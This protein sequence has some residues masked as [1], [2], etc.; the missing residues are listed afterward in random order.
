M[1]SDRKT[2]VSQ[3]I[4]EGPFAGGDSLLRRIFGLYIWWRTWAMIVGVAAAIVALAEFTQFNGQI[5]LAWG[6]GIL[7]AWWAEA[8]SDDRLGVFS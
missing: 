6:V 3:Y 2:G 1:S 4:R 5:I 8:V 7:T